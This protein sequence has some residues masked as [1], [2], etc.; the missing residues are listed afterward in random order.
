MAR[1]KGFRSGETPVAAIRAAK[2][3]PKIAVKP[4]DHA[5][6]NWRDVPGFYADVRGTMAA[7]PRSA[8]RR[9]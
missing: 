3:L 7:K 4:K 8:R 9:Q 2:V 5:A 1:S 6:M